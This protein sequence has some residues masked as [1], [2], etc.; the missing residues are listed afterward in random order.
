VAVSQK[1]QQ[2]ETFQKTNQGWMVWKS[3]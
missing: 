3:P 1:Q 2:I